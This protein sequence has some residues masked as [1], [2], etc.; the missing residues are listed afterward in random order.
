MGGGEYKGTTGVVKPATPSRSPF[1]FP[2]RR[3]ALGAADDQVVD[4]LDSH[5]LAGR[6]HAAHEG[7]VLGAGRWIAAR[8]GM[9]DNHAPSA[10]QESLLEDLSRLDR[11]PA[12]G[13]AVDRSLGD[14]AASRVDQQD[15]DD[16][17]VLDAVPEPDVLRDLL[18]GGYR[19]PVRDLA[20]YQT[21][22]QF[23]VRQEGR[24]LEVIQPSMPQDRGAHSNKGGE[25]AVVPE[26]FAGEI[27]GGKVRLANT[28][29][30]GQKLRIGEHLSATTQKTLAGLLFLRQRQRQA[31]LDGKGILSRALAWHPLVSTEGPSARSTGRS[32]EQGGDLQGWHRSASPWSRSHAST[33]APPQRPRTALPLEA[34]RLVEDL[35]VLLRRRRKP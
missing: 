7:A 3:P 33:V 2:E 16:L 13:A 28:E 31:A 26:D 25:A 4:H 15:T 12:E 32:Q 17:L 19:L 30:D 21:T 35:M 29:Q 8:A 6:D 20:P 23:E 10:S 34:G 22:R 1:P 24:D 9:E 18:S 5:H 27:Y 11:G 14:Q